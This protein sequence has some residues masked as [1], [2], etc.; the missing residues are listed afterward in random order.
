MAAAMPVPN[1]GLDT[2][3]TVRGQGT[4]TG[5]HQS[6]SIGARQAGAVGV[7]QG[8]MGVHQGSMGMGV[9]RAA[10]ICVQCTSLGREMRR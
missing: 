10:W 9:R 4:S 5:V 6:A 3:R 1:H 7:H 2:R 8:S